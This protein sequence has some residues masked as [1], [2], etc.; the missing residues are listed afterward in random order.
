MASWSARR[1]LTY[2]FIFFALLLAAL[3]FAALRFWPRAS[4]QDGRRNQ[5]EL[6]IDCGG[7]PVGGCPAVCATEAL[8]PRALWARVLPLGTGPPRLGEAGAYDLVALISNPNPDLVA[9]NLPYEIKFVDQGNNLINS[10]QDKLSLWPQETFPVFFPDIKVGRRVPARA[11]L[12]F[13]GAPRWARA[14]SSPPTL[15]ITDDNFTALPTPVLK[16]RL[17]NNSLKLAAQI[18]V[19]AILS[20]AEHNAFAASTTFIPR[21]APSETADFSFTWP[22]PFALPPTFTEFYSHVAIEPAR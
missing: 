12:E 3:A 21:L 4:C 2:F 13:T 14:S 7:P 5:R 16:A 8:P 1:Q 11:Y 10:V 9:T 6:G 20:D 19:A 18:E 17:T 15:T 22:R